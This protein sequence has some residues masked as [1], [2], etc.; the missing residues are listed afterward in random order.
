MSAEELAEFREAGKIVASVIHP[1]TGKPVPAL[2][3]M[4]GFVVV[5]LPISFLLLMSKPTTFNILFS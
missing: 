4:S 2:G 3:R 1:D 5:N